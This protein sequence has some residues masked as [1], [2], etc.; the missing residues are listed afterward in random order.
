[1]IGI[2]MIAVVAVILFTVPALVAYLGRRDK[3]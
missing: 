2:G 1:M 3:K